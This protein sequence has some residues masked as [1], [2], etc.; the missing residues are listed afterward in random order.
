MRTL[1]VI[2]AG[3]LGAFAALSLVAATKT[4]NK[5]TYSVVG[6]YPGLAQPAPA[7]VE[8]AAH[9]LGE[10]MAGMT[11]VANPDDAEHKVQILFRR[12]S[13]EIYV[14]ALPLEKRP[15]AGIEKQSLF[16]QYQQ[17]DL[18]R[19]YADGNNGK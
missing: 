11:Q 10:K 5:N 3:L 15:P 7:L 1:R 6:Y 13:F 14:D 18:A 12:D 17:G 16:Q 2:V 19:D 9:A 4:Q 8:K